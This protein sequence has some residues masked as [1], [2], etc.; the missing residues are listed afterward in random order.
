MK[1]YVTLKAFDVGDLNRSIRS[2]VVTAKRTGAKIIGPIALPTRRM[3]FILN[4]STHVHKKARE[5]FGMVIHPRLIG[6]TSVSHSTVQSLLNLQIPSG[7]SIDVNVMGSDGQSVSD[8]DV[9]SL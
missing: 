9:G 3:K 6:L 1:I 5:Q 8:E 4:T 2:I 7:V